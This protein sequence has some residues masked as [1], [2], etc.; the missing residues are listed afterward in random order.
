MNE[1]KS[2]FSTIKTELGSKTT[3]TESVATKISNTPSSSST[4]VLSES[5]A[6]ENPQFSR[7]K[8]MMRKIK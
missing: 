1:A 6:Y 2:L 5:K 3:V 8:E 7:I 4:G